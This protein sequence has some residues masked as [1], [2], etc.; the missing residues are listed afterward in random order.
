MWVLAVG[1]DF[2]K[3]TLGYDLGDRYESEE[4]DQ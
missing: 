1:V 4:V 3:N 2:R